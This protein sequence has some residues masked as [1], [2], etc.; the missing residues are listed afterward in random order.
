MPCQHPQ[1]TPR[2][3][4]QR[5]AYHLQQLLGG[6]CEHSS[7][8]GQTDRNR[9]RAR[10]RALIHC[11]GT[12]GPS[13]WKSRSNWSRRRPVGGAGA[14]KQRCTNGLDHSHI[15]VICILRPVSPFF[16]CCMFAPVRQ[17]NEDV[18]GGKEG[19]EEIASCC[20]FRPLFPAVVLL[21]LV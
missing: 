21:I 20:L 16:H 3:W 17:S 9:T 12:C 4:G 7:S 10:T 14:V 19:E 5:E 15:P 1:D 18:E 6:R 11:P 13:K 2:L 8:C